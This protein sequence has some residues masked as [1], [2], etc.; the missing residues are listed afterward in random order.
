MHFSSLALSYG[1]LLDTFLGQKSEHANSFFSREQTKALN[2]LIRQAIRIR[3]RHKTCGALQ[4][5]TYD[6]CI[7]V[8]PSIRQSGTIFLVCLYMTSQSYG[9]RMRIW[10]AC[11][12]IYSQLKVTDTNFGFPIIC[13]PLGLNRWNSQGYIDTARFC[14]L[15]FS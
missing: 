10:M 8:F 11:L 2:S 6:I 4:N 12:S 14:C 9:C 1:V 7:C 15:V 3:I 5:R 13:R